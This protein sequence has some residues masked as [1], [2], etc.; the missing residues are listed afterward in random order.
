MKYFVL[1]N[2]C[3]VRGGLASCYT[4]FQLKSSLICGSDHE[5]RREKE[6]AKTSGENGDKLLRRS[7]RVYGSHMD[8]IIRDGS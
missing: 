3:F 7:Q 2:E 6:H 5:S 1:A 4:H 8:D